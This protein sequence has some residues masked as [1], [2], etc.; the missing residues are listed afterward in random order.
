MS[1]APGE[2]IFDDASVFRLVP[3]RD[4][5]LAP[6]IALW[7]ESWQATMPHIDFSARRDWFRAH[8]QASEEEGA[9]TI[10]GFDAEGNLAG[11]LLLFMQRNYLEQVAVHPRHFRSGL[12]RR[13]LDEAKARCPH[14]LTL[15]VNADNARALQFYQRHGCVRVAAGTNPRSGLP[16]FTMR[17]P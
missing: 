17:W 2:Q 9:L 16:T 13:L 10:C 7:V 1:A 14:G 3:R 4:D 12:A 6:L 15:D 11:F 8:L 5:D